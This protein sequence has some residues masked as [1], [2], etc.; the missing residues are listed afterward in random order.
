MGDIGSLTT[1]DK[2]GKL[3]Q[4]EYALNRVNQ[5]KMSLGIKGKDNS[6]F[7]CLLC[8]VVDYFDNYTYMLL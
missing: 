8:N 1:F 7:S 3:T 4:I 2:S 5:G 6:H